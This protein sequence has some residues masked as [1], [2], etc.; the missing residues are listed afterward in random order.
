MDG[1]HYL[2][3]LSLV[4]VVFMIG[5]YCMVVTNCKKKDKKDG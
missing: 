4:G 1:I 5:H 2:C 3:A